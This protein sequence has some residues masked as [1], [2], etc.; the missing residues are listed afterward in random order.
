MEERIS[1]IVPVYRAE[2]YLAR[3]VDSVLAQSHRD[4]ELIL[5]DDG[6]PDGCP[7]LCDAYARRDP[8]VKVIHRENGGIAEA[9]N[10]GLDAAGGG[11]IAFVDSDDWVEP[12]FLE[13]LLLGA[14]DWGADLALC[15][16]WR[17][18]PARREKLGYDRAACL[19]P[20][21]ALEDLLRERR[22]SSHLWNKLYRRQLFEGIRFPKGRVYEDVA[23]TYRLVERARAV[24]V[25][26]EAKVHYRV[27]PDGITE[28]GGLEN[29]LDYWAAAK[30]RCDAL[31]PRYPERAALLRLAPM[32][33]AIEAWSRVWPRR[34]ELTGPQKDA[35]ADMTAFVRQ[36]GP[37]ALAGDAFGP[38]GRLRLRAIAHP[39]GLS[40]WFAWQMGRLYRKKH[41]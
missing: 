29:H 28:S 33:A 30:G 40:Y 10:T 36:Y 4:L 37:E 20:R 22:L 15:A 13:Y 11:W 23:V 32:S 3:C 5:V 24:A 17:E 9:R 38:T 12:D 25:L 16:Y 31:L 39:G 34:R 35:L 18:G 41:G 8:R 7:A 26:P 14:R 21:Q 27:N 19:T 6:S 2:P 1:V